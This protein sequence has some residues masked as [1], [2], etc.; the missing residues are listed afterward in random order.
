MPSNLDRIEDVACPF[1]GL[2]CDDL[3]VTTLPNGELGQCENAC[4][5]G[6]QFF[7]NACRPRSNC[8]A[9]IAGQAATQQQATDHAA[10]LLCAAQAPLIA[11]LATD[12]AGMRAAVRL[13][14]QTNAGLDHMN[15]RGVLKNQRVMQRTGW[16]TTTLSEIRNRADLV[17]II[18]DRILDDY[19]RLIDRVLRPADA[20]LPTRTAKR[21]IIAINDAQSRDD[22][23]DA[24]RTIKKAIDTEISTGSQSVVDLLFALRQALTTGRETESGSNTNLQNLTNAI[25][26]SEYT[27]FIWSAGRLDA[28][29]ADIVIDTIGDIVRH[30]NVNGRAA[31]LPIAGSQGDLTANQ[32][33]TW[34]TGFPL[35][36]RFVDGQPQ[37]DPIGLDSQTRIADASVDCLLWIE[38][39]APTPAPTGVATNIII[40][41]DI[42]HHAAVDADVFLPVDTPG[43]GSSGLMVRTDHVVTVPLKAIRSQRAPSVAKVLDSIRSAIK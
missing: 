2:V 38:S 21:Q 36:M 33:C 12:V 31:G 14:Q 5:R 6:E 4:A 8:T 27:V 28:A 24:S 10:R 23:T 43:V 39:L 41:S 18:D 20:L 35:R 25:T 30:I 11:G 26:D 17:V 42:E 16:F 32:V 34:Q 7:R 15:G 22:E 37:A 40:G 3:I 9:L 19:P 13:A 1:C 29:D